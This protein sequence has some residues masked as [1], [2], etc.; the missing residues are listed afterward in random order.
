M[1]LKT[2]PIIV[3]ILRLVGNISMADID[4]QVVTIGQL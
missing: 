4:L 2:I 3:I 1:P